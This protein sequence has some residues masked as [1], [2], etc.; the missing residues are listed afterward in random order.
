[1]HMSPRK[2][3]RVDKLIRGPLVE[4]MA[5]LNELTV[6]TEPI[7]CVQWPRPIQSWGNLSWGRDHLCLEE[8]DAGNDTKRPRKVCCAEVWEYFVSIQQRLHEI[9]TR[10]FSSIWVAFLSRWPNAAFPYAFGVLGRVVWPHVNRQK[11]TVG[12]PRQKTAVLLW[13]PEAQSMTRRDQ[14]YPKDCF[15]QLTPSWSF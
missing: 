10:T 2:M 11:V 14:R 1:M 8:T 13:Q 6:S 15:L 3:K 4:W 12:P 7:K 9:F 5:W